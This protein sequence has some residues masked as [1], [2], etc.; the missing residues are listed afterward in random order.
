MGLNEYLDDGQEVLVDG[1]DGEHVTAEAE[2]PHQSVHDGQTE[3]LLALEALEEQPEAAQSTEAIDQV[4]EPAARR[5]HV[6][7]LGED[8]H[9]HR[10]GVGGGG[11]DPSTAATALQGTRGAAASTPASTAATAVPV[12]GCAARGPERLAARRKV[13]ASRGDGG[14]HNTQVCS[15]PDQQTVCLQ[16]KLLLSKMSLMDL[17]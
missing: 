10:L 17:H 7:R 3:V 16:G 11:A 14:R 5:P 12:A 8:F 13:P 2:R 9:V 6:G 4:D 1:G 15:H